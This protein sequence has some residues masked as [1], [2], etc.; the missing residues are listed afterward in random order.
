MIK[1]NKWL[2]VGLITSCHGINGQ[3]KVKSLSDFEERFL[4]PGERWLQKEKE[5]PIKIELTS[6]YKQPGKKTFIIKFQGI[7]SR[8]HAEQLKK[9][10]ILVKADQ[11]PKLNKEEFHLLELVNLQVKT[12]ENKVIGKVINLENEKNNLLVIELFNNHKKVLIPFVD[13]IVPLVDIKN[14]FLIINPPKG[15]LE[16]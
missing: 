16:L 15:L 8:N 14:N 6:G 4:I 9:Y 11:L 13:E 2:V 5:S 7:S 1:N 12:I 10:K 3:V